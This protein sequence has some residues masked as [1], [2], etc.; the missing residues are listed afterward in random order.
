M[1]IDLNLK[2]KVIINEELRWVEIYKLTNIV[3]KKIYIGQ[4]ISHIR[5]GNKFVPHGTNGRFN[6]HVKEATGK[7]K[8][9]Y[10]CR[11]LNNAI[12]KYGVDNFKIETLYNCDVKDSNKLES[13]EIYKNIS[14]SPIGYNLTT[15]CKSYLPSIEFRQKISSGLINSLN[16]KRI[17]RMIKY[18]LNIQDDYDKYI[19]PKYINNNIIGYRIRIKDIV[20]SDIKILPNKGLE[21]TSLIISIEENKI[22][23]YEFL[24]LLKEKYQTAT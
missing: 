1:N 3:N 11:I 5:K 23:A 7:N 24:K 12:V 6:T 9:K 8:G 4:A 14:L 15:S 17:E 10:S 22:R 19:I 21:F 20:L 2:N 16:D 13:E 18:K